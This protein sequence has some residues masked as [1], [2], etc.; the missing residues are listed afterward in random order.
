LIA[1]IDYG[2]GNLRSV[3]NGFARLG[4]S[5]AVTRDK[6]AIAEARA[7]VFARRGSLWQVHG[8]PGGV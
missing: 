3:T 5:I 4:A 2:M 8:K 1:I 7:I 6:G